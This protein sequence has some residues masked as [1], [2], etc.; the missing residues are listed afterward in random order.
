MLF[1]EDTDQVNKES[2]E[3]GTNGS[4]EMFLSLIIYN[5]R[6]EHS[7][8]V[9]LF[10]QTSVHVFMPQRTLKGISWKHLPRNTA[11]SQA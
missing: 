5:I 4:T 6:L 2:E 10:L 3:P 8:L 1:K 9:S 7:V 11:Q